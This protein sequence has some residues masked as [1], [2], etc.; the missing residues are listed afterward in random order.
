MLRELR[1]RNFAVIE[2]VAVE[3]RP[4]LNVLTGETGAGKSMLIDA[5]LLVLGARAQTDV[6]RSDADAATVEAV[7]DVEP[8][9][10]VAVTLEEAGLALDDGV[11]VARRELSRSGRHRAFVNDA[12]VTVA[13]LERLGDHLVEVHGQHEHQRLLEP[14]RQ[15]ELLDRFADAEELRE[16]VAGLVAKFRAARAEAERTRAA[17][18]D[19]AQRE[20]LLRFQL[21]ELDGARL[22]PGEEEELRQE[23]R[24]LQHAD[25]LTA[26]FAEVAALLDDDRDS[27]TA[28]LHRATR[29]LGDLARLDPAVAAPVEPLDAAQAQLE[30]VLAAVRVLRESVLAEPGRLEAIDE[31][32]DVLTRLKRKYGDTEEAMLKFRD[33][34]A[35]E[36]DRFARHEEILAAEERR[37]GELQAELGQA[38][39]ELS[40]RRRA[41]TESLGPAVE[42]ELRALGME[43]SRFRIEL[44][45]AEREDV[46]PRG[47]ER[48]EFRLSTNPG[49]EVRPLARV[50][51]GGELS[52]TMLG[53]TTVLAKADRVPTMVFDEVDAGIGG[54]VAA[55]VA[56]KLAAVAA[57]RQVLCVTHLAPIAA[58]ADH[59]VRVSKSLRAGRSRVAVEG[60]AG[61]ARVEE[62]ARMLA[63]ER[64]TDTARGHARELLGVSGSRERRA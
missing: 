44:E 31:R 34:V 10:P 64:V 39:A 37:L 48:V 2:S 6:I 46:S 42:R 28:R 60:L 4:G 13:L 54:R 17:E 5:I 21:S 15:L 41:A 47:L 30:E 16:R 36:F 53:L 25:K 43:R 55:V 9:G 56:Q 11:L 33:E 3:F 49:E 62:I 12:A 19:R 14:A 59:H 23:R 24:R 35:A 40:E 51:S 1:I 26:G 7:F 61:D 45:R 57:G 27:A 50:A 52:R 29:I 58:R 8:R 38:A 63:G 22:R 20:D 18:R 32:L